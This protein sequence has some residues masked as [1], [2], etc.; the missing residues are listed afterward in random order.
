MAGKEPT[1]EDG[2]RYLE[3]TATKATG[4]VISLDETCV[5]LEESPRFGYSLKGQRCVSPPEE[6]GE[7]DRQGV[8]PPRHL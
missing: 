8:T 4:E 2:A 5:Y 7:E 3:D 1:P 6:C